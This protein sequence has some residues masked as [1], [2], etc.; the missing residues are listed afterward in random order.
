MPALVRLWPSESPLRISR[1]CAHGA[2]GALD[3][4]SEPRD[5]DPSNHLSEQGS[6]RNLHWR[7]ECKI[8]EAFW[9]L[10]AG[11]QNRNIS[12]DV[13]VKLSTMEEFYRLGYLADCFDRQLSISMIKPDEGGVEVV[14]NGPC[15]ARGG[16]FPINGEFF[17]AGGGEHQGVL[18]FGLLPPREKAH[19]VDRREKLRVRF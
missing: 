6:L 18:S 3:R 5:F 14:Y 16:R 13:V 11:Y 7:S 12:L 17:V 15:K 9:K 19:S 2:V 4:R 8:G 1:P 10:V